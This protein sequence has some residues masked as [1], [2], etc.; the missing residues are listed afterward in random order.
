M[1]SPTNQPGPPLL[2]GVP[3]VSGPFLP[4]SLNKER[5][6]FVCFSDDG[7]LFGEDEGIVPVVDAEDL[8]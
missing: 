4:G 8:L 2:C 3:R 7:P 5:V 6:T 1:R